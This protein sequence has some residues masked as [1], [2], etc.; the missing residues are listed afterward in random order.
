MERQ[1]KIEIKSKDEFWGR[2]FHV[3]WEHQFPDRKL[4]PSAGNFFF[5][6]IEWL[7]DLEQVGAQTF[8]TITR[9]PV[10]PQRREWIGKLTGRRGRN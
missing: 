6:Q 5:A 10:N 2:A 7:G 1:I 8:S 9:A 3:E 4:Q